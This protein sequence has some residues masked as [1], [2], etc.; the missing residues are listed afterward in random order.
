M[1]DEHQLPIDETL[2][3]DANKTGGIPLGMQA[4]AK[5]GGDVVDRKNKAAAAPAGR[6]ADRSD[7]LED[8]TI[9]DHGTVSRVA[10]SEADAIGGDSIG[11][12]GDPPSPLTGRTDSA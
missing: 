2:K 10:G 7:E 11:D 3:P 12:D 1:S 8:A 4:G 9:G 5:A 6:F